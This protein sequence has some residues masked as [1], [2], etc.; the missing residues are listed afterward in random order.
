MGYEVHIE[1][2]DRTPITLE[3]WRAAVDTT[4]GIRLARSAACAVNPKTGDKI[5]IPLQPGDAEV[6]SSRR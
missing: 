4:E 5:T 2:D 6:L 1:R 3:E